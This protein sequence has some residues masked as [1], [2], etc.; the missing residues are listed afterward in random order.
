M[1][2]MGKPRRKKTVR[3]GNAPARALFTRWGA[4]WPAVVNACQYRTYGEE[5]AGGADMPRRSRLG[6][7]ATA[8]AILAG[9]FACQDAISCVQDSFRHIRGKNRGQKNAVA[10]TFSVQLFPS[11]WYSCQWRHSWFGSVFNRC[12]VRGAIF[13]RSSFISC[14]LRSLRLLRRLVSHLF[15]PLSTNHRPP[16]SASISQLTAVV[17]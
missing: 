10:G 16:V 17:K 14:L 2:S 9:K 11:H 3:T 12:S 5:T 6:H 13:T 15:Y 4:S 1:R 8:T 7:I